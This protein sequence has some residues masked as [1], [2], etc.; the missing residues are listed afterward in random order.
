MGSFTDVTLLISQF[1]LQLDAENAD[2]YYRALPHRLEA[3]TLKKLK[4]NDTPVQEKE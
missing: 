2:T 1:S 4:L 3:P